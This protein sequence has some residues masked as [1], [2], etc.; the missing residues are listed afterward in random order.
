MLGDAHRE[1]VGDILVGQRVP[2]ALPGDEALDA[3]QLV[4]HARGVVGVARQR[5]Q[6]RLL[7][8]EELEARAPAAS[9]EGPQVGDGVH[10]VGEL[11]ARSSRSRKLRPRKK[12]SVSSQKLLSTRG[13]SLGC[14]GR[15]G[16]GRELVVGGEVEEARIVDR[17]AALPAQHHRLLA[18]V[19]AWRAAPSKRSKACTWPSISACSPLPS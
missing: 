18:V 6:Q 10:P 16:H 17:L 11:A 7:L 2:V 5:A 13:L 8:G 14:R 1:D 19:L 12:L 3:A 9:V 4:E 15:H